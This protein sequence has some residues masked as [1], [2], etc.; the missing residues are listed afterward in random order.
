VRSIRQRTMLDADLL[1]W[2]RD[3]AP[4]S[5]STSADREFDVILAGCLVG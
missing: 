3:T 4:T 2:I 1:L 5:T